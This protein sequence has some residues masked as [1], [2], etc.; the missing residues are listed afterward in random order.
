MDTDLLKTGRFSKKEHL[1]RPADIQKIFKKGKR[2]S[3]KGAKLFYLLNDCQFNRIGFPLPRGYGN[4]VERNTSKR[5][6]REIYRLF[7]THLNTGYDILL[8][9]YPGNDSFLSRCEQFKTLCQK[10]GLLKD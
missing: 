4:A 6:S 3:V 1:K 10:A 8:L 9:V 2:F 5:Y 7:K